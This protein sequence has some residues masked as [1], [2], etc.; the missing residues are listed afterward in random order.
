MNKEAKNAKQKE[1]LTL[2]ALL[3]RNPIPF[4]DVRKYYYAACIGTVILLTLC[5]HI[6]VVAIALRTDTC[7]QL[8][9]VFIVFLL[10]FCI[11]T[12]V[13]HQMRSFLGYGISAVSSLIV[14]LLLQFYHGTGVMII[15]DLPEYGEV[16][17]DG[18]K[19]TDFWILLAKAF[20]VI[21]LLLTIV[22]INSTLKVKEE[23]PLKGMNVQIQK[24]KDWLDKNNNS[25][26]PGRRASDYWFVAV[27][28][29]LWMIFVAY[30]PTMGKY[31]Y[32][33]M[34]LLMAGVAAVFLRWTFTGSFFISSSAL[35]RCTLYQYRFGLCIPVVAAYLGIWVALLYLILETMRV[36]RLTQ[37]EKNKPRMSVL[38]AV[39]PWLATACFVVCF[40]IHE[41]TNAFS[42]SF[43][44]YQKDNLPLIFFLPMMVF[45]ALMTRRWWGYLFATAGFVWLWDSIK[46]A[47]PLYGG[48]FFSFPSLEEHGQIGERTTARMM[49]VANGLSV[50]LIVVAVVCVCI[51]VVMMLF[52]R[53]K[54]KH[55]TEE[56]AMD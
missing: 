30:D 35:I 29:I 20:A 51:S 2:T 19:S 26:P 8:S 56:P 24:I 7:E 10:I 23:P 36:R 21:H 34:G 32:W 3:R 18:A 25:L 12:I 49:D 39:F 27:S 14:L 53:R 5:F 46:H 45:L 41:M 4:G 22:F 52:V 50:A 42:G 1:P 38:Q 17:R 6:S 16:F 47:T 33:S 31:D 55:G 44:V 13:G 37:Q 48:R 9:N 28:L 40:S 43:M 54:D 15:S 11:A